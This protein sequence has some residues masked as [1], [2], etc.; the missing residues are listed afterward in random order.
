MSMVV[1]SVVG[2]TGSLVPGRVGGLCSDDIGR[3]LFLWVFG[4]LSGRTFT[5]MSMIVYDGVQCSYL[6]ESGGDDGD[7]GRLR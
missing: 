1:V 4:S 3:R 6:Y 7:F 5:V 2:S